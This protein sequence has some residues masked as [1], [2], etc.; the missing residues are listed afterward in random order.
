MLKNLFSSEVRILLLNRFLMNEDREFYLRQLSG[1]FNLS[2]RH[3]SLELQNLKKIGLITKRISGNLHYFT[4][5]RQHPLF[6][7]LKNIFLKTVGLKDIIHKYLISFTNRI[8]FAFIYGSMARGTADSDSDVDLM[9]VGDIS[10]RQISA[11]MIKAGNE[12]KREI[13]F[14]VF[15]PEEFKTRLV[16]N[17]HFVSS[18]VSESKL[19]IIGDMN[20]FERLVQ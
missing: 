12:L 9:I 2:P 19:F 1:D 10:T 16:K 15:N 7:E 8:Q 4:I 5:N 14:S 11:E 6:Q 18:L 20:E 13:N 3:V 17:D